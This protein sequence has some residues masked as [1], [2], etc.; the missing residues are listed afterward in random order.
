MRVLFIEREGTSPT[1]YRQNAA[2][3]QAARRIPPP[4]GQPPNPRRLS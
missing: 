3:A 4:A 2:Q 1:A